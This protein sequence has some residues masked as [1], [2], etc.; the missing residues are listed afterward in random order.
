M[1][2]SPQRV[3]PSRARRRTH[4]WTLCTHENTPLYGAKR[5]SYSVHTSDVVNTNKTRETPAWTT[6][7]ARSMTSGRRSPRG[8]MYAHLVEGK[9][10]RLTLTEIEEGTRFL[11]M[12]PYRKLHGVAP[13]PEWLSNR[14]TVLR[15]HIEYTLSKPARLM[16]HEHTRSVALARSVCMYLSIYLSTGHDSSISHRGTLSIDRLARGFFEKGEATEGGGEN[17]RTDERVDRSSA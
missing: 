15:G 3:S 4:T 5:Y 14:V 8:K 6:D 7:D 10:L 17:G 12:S 2:A 16:G 1:D 9:T 11:Q 13:N